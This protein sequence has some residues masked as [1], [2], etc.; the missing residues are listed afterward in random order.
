MKIKSILFACSV[1]FLSSQFFT[2][3]GQEAIPGSAVSAKKR[4]VITKH[5]G[6]EFIGTIITQDEREI[7][8][9]TETIGRVYIPKH[10]ILSIEVL[11]DEDYRGGRYLGENLYATR[12]FITTNGLPMKKGDSYALINLFG[13]EYQ[14]AV[15][16]NFTLGAITSWVGIPLIGSA[17]YA[18]AMGEKVSGAIG[19]LIGSGSWASLGSAGGLVYGALTVGGSRSNISFS[20]GYAGVT[21]EGD[22]GS[23]PLFSVAGM[24][25]INEKVAFVFDSFIYTKEEFFALIIPGLRFYRPNKGAFQF[26]FGGIAVEGEVLPVPVPMISW[27]VRI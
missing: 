7:L 12:Y 2:I 17:K 11:T 6:A 19:T 24:A 4:M 13:P 26:G 27:F 15:A 20:A 16:N 23:A 25:R 8:M 5:D 22:V 21:I 10:E 1:L 3:S 9:E 14:A 18:F